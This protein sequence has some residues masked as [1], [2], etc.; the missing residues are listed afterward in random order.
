MPYN[1]VF[2]DLNMDNPVTGAMPTRCHG[3]SAEEKCRS[4]E[5]HMLVFPK[6]K[7]TRL[8]I[9]SESPH[10]YGL[11]RPVDIARVGVG[12]SECCRDENYEMFMATMR[13]ILANRTKRRSNSMPVD[14]FDLV[15]RLIDLDR[16][17]T[18]GDVYWTHVHKRSIVR[19]P[20]IKKTDQDEEEWCKKRFDGCLDRFLMDE[21][22][23]LRPEAVVIISFRGLKFLT[24]D[25]LIHVSRE[26]TKMI[27][28]NPDG[29]TFTELIA[30]MG[31][32]IPAGRK[33][34]LEAIG[35]SE[36]FVLPNP[37]NN[38][39]QTRFYRK[40]EVEIEFSRLLEWE[41]NRILSIYK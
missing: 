35:S 26:M 32:Q 7:H 11:R 9:I 1:D 18:K 39:H 28:N 27:S 38:P 40:E 33:N 17:G 34:V 5:R 4:I 13:S 23:S 37:G 24:G 29:I 14:I 41:T 12:Q 3:C 15:S 25:G 36:I 31:S 16:L 20:A 2:T 19:D 10:A 21:I 6:P 8:M 30:H 22:R